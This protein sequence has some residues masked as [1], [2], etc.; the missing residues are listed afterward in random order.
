MKP[1]DRENFASAFLL[2]LAAVAALV[3]LGA[4]LALKGW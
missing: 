4:Q 3:T 1:W 2:T